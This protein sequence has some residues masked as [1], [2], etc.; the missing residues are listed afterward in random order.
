MN[1]NENVEL[2]REVTDELKKEIVSFANSYGGT[3]YIGIEDD[4]KIKGVSDVD[5]TMLKI[6]SMIRDAIHPDITMFVRVHSD[7]MKD[8]DVIL[9]DISEGTNKPYH[10]AK[11]GLKPSGVYVRQGSAS[12][13]ASDEQIR[14]MIKLTDGDTYE[15]EVSVLQDLTFS[16]AKDVFRQHNMKF[17]NEQMI[18]LGLRKQNKLWTNLGQLLSDQCPFSVKT[19]VFAG[20][21]QTEFKDRKEFYGSLLKQLEDS[22]EFIQLN[23]PTAASFQG[24]YRKDEK[25]YPD[26]ALRE[27]LLNSIIHRDYSYSASTLISIYGDRIEFVSIGGLLP[28]IHKEDIMLGISVCRNK[29]LADI[30]YRLDLIEAYGTGIQ[31]IR[32]A[33]GAS[34]SKPEI[35]VAPNSFKII[36]PQMV[37]DDALYLSEENT[38][39]QQT[40]LDYIETNG[41]ITREKVETILQVSPSTAGRILRDM[42]DN[43]LII[44]AGRGKGTRYNKNNSQN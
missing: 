3:I 40:V 19:A 20:K 9:I 22:Y 34:D 39:E 41:T 30:F 18:T 6:T 8:H 37:Y 35:L 14:Q 32:N 24:L 16:K 25:S 36:L 44:K 33:Y 11:N 23:N 5:G 21:D 28:G 12:A 29:K 13:Q 4:G 31:K 1:E 42:C 26:D 15:D 38:S 2:K 17:A 7:K 27:A 43:S 10:I